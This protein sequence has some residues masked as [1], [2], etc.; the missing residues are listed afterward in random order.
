MCLVWKTCTR[1][2]LNLNVETRDEYFELGM[3]NCLRCKDYMYC[4][5]KGL[6]DNNKNIFKNKMIRSYVCVRVPYY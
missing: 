3:K 5:Y 6:E 4:M 1:F 2:K